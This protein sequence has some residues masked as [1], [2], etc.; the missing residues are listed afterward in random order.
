MQDRPDIVETLSF[1]CRLN[2]VETEAMR[3]SPRRT[4]ARDS[5]STPAP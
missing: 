2:L 4:G 3:A 5:S 1:G